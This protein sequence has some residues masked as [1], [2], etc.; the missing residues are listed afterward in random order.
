MNI[1]SV[2]TILQWVLPSGSLGAVV[3]WFVSRKGRRLDMLAKMQKSIDDLTK[4]YTEVLDE[5]VRLKGDKA[6]LLAQMREMEIKMD[7][8]NA[9]VDEL[10][11]QLKNKNNERNQ[12]N[13]SGR[14][15]PVRGGRTAK[16]GGSLRSGTLADGGTVKPPRSSISAGRRGIPGTAHPHLPVDGEQPVVAA[17]GDTEYAPKGTGS[18]VED[19]ELPPDRM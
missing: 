14:R 9:K 7:M 19:P 8:L 4:K 2:I 11:E 10:T 6:D 12:I 13:S 18:V 17:G 16:Q 5:N 15:T 3:G 1:E